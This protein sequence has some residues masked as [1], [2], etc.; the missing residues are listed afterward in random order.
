M[1]WGAVWIVAF[2]FPFRR[3]RCDVVQTRYYTVRRSLVIPG[4]NCAESRQKK[5]KGC[6]K[7]SPGTDFHSCVFFENRWG[8][9][10]FMMFRCFRFLRCGGGADSGF[11]STECATWCESLFR[12]ILRYCAL[13]FGQ[14]VSHRTASHCK[15]KKRKHRKNVP[16]TLKSIPF[17]AELGIPFRERTHLPNM[18]TIYL[19]PYP[20]PDF[21]PRSRYKVSD[22]VMFHI[23]SVTCVPWGIGY[24]RGA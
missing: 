2:D 18:D 4:K 16:E 12:E 3:V 17:P 7:L 20:Y 8:S 24:T 22:Y 10:P 23:P 6:Q 9:V 21:V 14:T 11:W 5:N 1:R 19:Y 13:R 15:K